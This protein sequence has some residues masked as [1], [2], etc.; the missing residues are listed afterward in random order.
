MAL[1]EPLNPEGAV[2]LL[3]EVLAPPLALESAVLALSS[4][5]L[6]SRAI[7]LSLLTGAFP[8]SSCSSDALAFRRLSI[9]VVEGVSCVCSTVC[10]DF[11]EAR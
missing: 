8:W 7:P 9:P 4:V 10:T 6:A 5:F 3:F 11:M 2:R 1:T